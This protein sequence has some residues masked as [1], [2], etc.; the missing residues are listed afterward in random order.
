MAEPTPTSGMTGSDFSSI[1]SGVTKMGTQ[2]G[3]DTLN[4][5]TTYYAMKAQVAEN[6]R[7]EAQK[8]SF[9]NRQMGESQRQFGVETGLKQ[10]ELGLRSTELKQNAK[11]RKFEN[12]MKARQERIG[13]SQGLTNGINSMIASR[14]ENINMMLARWRQMA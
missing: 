5:I 13:I 2:A 9:F 14:P 10:Q 6:K 7:T 12:D 3:S 11:Q 8:L 4:A 1:A